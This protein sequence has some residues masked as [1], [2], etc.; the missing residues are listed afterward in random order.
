MCTPHPSRPSRHC[1]AGDCASGCATVTRRPQWA[2]GRTRT[3]LR[4]HARGVRRGSPAAVARSRHLAHPHPSQAPDHRVVPGADGQRRDR[5]LHR[6]PRAVQHHARPGQGRHPLPPRRH[7][8]RG[9]RAGGL[10]DVEVRRRA[11]AVRR[12]QGRRRLRSHPDVEARARSADAPLRHGDHRRHRPREGRAGAGREHR[13][14]D[15]G[16]GD[17]HLQHARRPHRDRGRDRQAGGDGRLARAARG[18]RPRRDDR[19]ARGRQAPRARHQGRPRRDPGLRQ[20][21]VGLGGTAR[22]HRRPHRRRHRL[23]G[24]RLQRARPRRRGHARVR[25][26][27]TSRSTAFPAASR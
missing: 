8:R 21:R 11:R 3:D 2:H 10:D 27:R 24:R 4:R 12:R 26:R 5:G 23:E 20:R 15:H 7:A 1:S 17:G 6:L 25:R 16:V 18:H 13:R 14:A 19:H 22:G 9:D